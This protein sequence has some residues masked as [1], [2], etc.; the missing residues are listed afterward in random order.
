[1][2]I[3]GI[4]PQ[5]INHSTL[6]RGWHYA[7]FDLHPRYK[8]I[9]VRQLGWGNSQLKNKVHVPATTNHIGF[10]GKP[11]K[12]QTPRKNMITLTCPG[13]RNSREPDLCDM[14]R[15]GRHH[16]GIIVNLNN[17]LWGAC[18]GH[19]GKL[20]II[21]HLQFDGYMIYMGKLQYFTDIH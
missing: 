3:G 21:D 20:T 18:M 19:M 13:K 15:K 1:M 16:L 14:W 5:L 6:V 2:T 9:W 12:T 10:P 7:L 8:K 17:S 11:W 4:P